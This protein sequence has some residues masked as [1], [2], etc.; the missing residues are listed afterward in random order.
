MWT[1]RQTIYINTDT[2]KHVWM[3]HHWVEHLVHHKN[4]TEHKDDLKSSMKAQSDMIQGI[5]GTLGLA[6]HSHNGGFVHKKLAVY[7]DSKC[8]STT[9]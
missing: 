2:I 7:L 6:G 8:W 1:Y 4:S 3:Q 5:N 9:P